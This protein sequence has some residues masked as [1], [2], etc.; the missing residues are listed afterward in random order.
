VN[1]VTDHRIEALP[2]QE[3]TGVV[4]AVVTTSRD[5]A[6]AL[7]FHL[8]IGPAERPEWCD[9]IEFALDPEHSAALLGAAT[10][11]TGPAPG[12]V[13]CRVGVRFGGPAV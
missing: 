2:T 10:P 13:P 4:D 8:V 11:T 9:R 3:I 5:D 12:P 6:G 1:A 7:T